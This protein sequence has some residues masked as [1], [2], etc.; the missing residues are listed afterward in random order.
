MKKYLFLIFA[1]ACFSAGAQTLTAPQTKKVTKVFT[2]HGNTRT[3]D[4]FWLNNPNDTAVIPHLEKENAYTASYL[5]PTEGLQKKIYDE[6]VARIEQK[7]QSLPVEQNGYWYYSR[8]ETGSQYPLYC[9]KKSSQT[10][11]E[12]VF[13]DANAQAKGH[14]IY[15]IRGTAISH[16]GKWLALGADTTGSRRSALYIKNL[17][18]GTFLPEVIANTDGDYAWAADLKTL[19]YTLNDPTVRSYKVMKHTAGTDP[20]TDKEIFI[21]KDST[22]SVSVN[23]SNDNRFVFINSSSKNSN[24]VR[25]IDSQ[26]PAAG[27]VL[28][29][30]RLKDVLYFPEYKGETIFLY[31]LTIKRKILSWQVRR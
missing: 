25:Y 30:S 15:I 4:Y 6:L 26:N 27:P 24:D 20:A 16:D 1:A 10:A 5:K 28:I 21:E 2:E 7:F 3:D 17:A 8:F 11:P 29:Q 19:Y 31:K 22:F 9:R 18:D 13:L 12:E 23:T 14:K